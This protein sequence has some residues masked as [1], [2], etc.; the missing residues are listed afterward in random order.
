MRVLKSWRTVASFKPRGTF[1]YVQLKLVVVGCGGKLK[2]GTVQLHEAVE[3]GIIQFCKAAHQ[4]FIEPVI[5]KFIALLLQ[6]PLLKVHGAAVFAELKGPDHFVDINACASG[7]DRG[8]ALHIG[9]VK[10]EDPG[11]VFPVLDRILRVIA[12]PDLDFRKYRNGYPQGNVKLRRVGDLRHGKAARGLAQVREPD[13]VFCA[14]MQLVGAIGIG[15]GARAVGSLHAHRLQGVLLRAVE[16]SAAHGVLLP[17]GVLHKWN[18]EKKK[19]A[20]S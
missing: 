14:D 17:K 10:V 16:H 15:H 2:I 4:S 3:F 12:R 13:G 20:V 6:Q 5:N 8:H 18:T 11:V 9:L 1:F 19:H 7:A